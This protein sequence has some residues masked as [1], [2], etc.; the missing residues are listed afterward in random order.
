MDKDEFKMCFDTFQHIIRFQLQKCSLHTEV[1][2]LKYLVID[3]IR[4]NGFPEQF[5]VSNFQKT[6]CILSD[7]S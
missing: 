4:Q 2:S 6:V 3:K 5:K 7:I 1:S